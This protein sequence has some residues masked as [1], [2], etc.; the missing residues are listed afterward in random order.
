VAARQTVAAI[1]RPARPDAAIDTPLAG[2][3]LGIIR[4]V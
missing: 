4:R 3:M 1:A 2:W